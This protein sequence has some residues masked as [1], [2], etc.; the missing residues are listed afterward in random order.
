MQELDDC[1]D[2]VIIDECAQSLEIAAWIP[3][4]M[5]KK[6]IYAGDDK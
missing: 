2:V 5:A 6:V 4:L 3:T 1:F